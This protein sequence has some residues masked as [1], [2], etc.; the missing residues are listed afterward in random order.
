MD[1][2]ILIARYQEQ[3]AANNAFITAKS[4]YETQK[5]TFERALEREK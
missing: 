3:I 4:A 2:G 1:S 5:N